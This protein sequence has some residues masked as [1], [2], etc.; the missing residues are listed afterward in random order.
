MTDDAK[1]SEIAF[2]RGIPDFQS[3]D[4]MAILFS[5]GEK[6]AAVALAKV[7]DGWPVES[8]ASRGAWSAQ[9]V[10]LG[11]SVEIVLTNSLPYAQYVTAKGGGPTLASTLVV[12][13]LKEAKAAFSAEARLLI[14]QALRNASR[15]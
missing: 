6:Y 8:G 4:V 13:A 5:L 12:D 9:A 15:K 14:P 11:T 7:L 3:V 10:L 2:P 1:F